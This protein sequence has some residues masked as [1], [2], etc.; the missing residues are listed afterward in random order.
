MLCWE[1]QFGMCVC[2]ACLVIEF[3]CRGNRCGMES[4]EDGGIGV[5]VGVVDTWQYGD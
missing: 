1:L 4:V 2:I 3:Q 5:G